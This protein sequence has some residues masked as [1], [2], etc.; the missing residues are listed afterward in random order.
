MTIPDLSGLAVA[1]T[2][3]GSGLG[4]A[5]ALELARHGAGVL[6]NDID[7]V[8]AGRTAG[9]IAASGGRAVEHAGSVAVWSHAADLVERCIAELGAIDLLV[10]NA[11]VMHVAPPWQERE[12]ELREVVEVNL[13][14]TMFCGA[15]AMRSMHAR[16]GG[17]IINV[18]SGAHLGL[19]GASAYGA[20]KGAV[21][22]LTYAWAL[23][24][25]DHGIRANAV[26]PLA[27][28]AILGAWGADVAPRRIAAARLGSPALVAPLVVAL[29]S[30]ACAGVTGQVIRFDG[31]TLSALAAPHFARLGP[32]RGDWTAVDLSDAI[33]RE[34]PPG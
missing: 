4:R 32:E 28:T 19:A 10:N 21:V 33:A 22:S 9:E 27:E 34:L 1:V 30:P 18:T 8:A 12:A 6:V 20:T 2:G 29:A 16:G 14:G 7:A 5:Y 25:R 31:R 24:G 26:S 23:E 15:H 13:L 11:G 17:A 3:A